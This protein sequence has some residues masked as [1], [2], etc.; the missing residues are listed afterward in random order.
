L[1]LTSSGEHFHTA[2]D[3]EMIALLEGWIR[4][5]SRPQLATSTT[6]AIPMP[7]PTQSDATPKPPPLDFRA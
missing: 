1:T 3:M 2:G 7:P 5:L 6:I 4:T